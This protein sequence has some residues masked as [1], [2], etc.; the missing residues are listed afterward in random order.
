MLGCDG[1]EPEN[2]GKLASES[3]FRRLTTRQLEVLRQSLKNLT[4][5]NF[6]A[7]ERPVMS[8]G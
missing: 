7:G 4:G 8:A 3:K 5:H 2:N 6:T 1:T